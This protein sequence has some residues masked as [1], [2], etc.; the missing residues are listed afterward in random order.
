MARWRWHSYEISAFSSRIL[1]LSAAGCGTLRASPSMRLQRPD[2][3]M[4]CRLLHKPDCFWAVPYATEPH[5]LR[6]SDPCRGQDRQ[7]PIDDGSI[8]NLL[9]RRPISA[10]LFGGGLYQSPPSRG[11]PRMDVYSSGVWGEAGHISHQYGRQNLHYQTTCRPIEPGF[12]RE[13]GSGRPACSVRSFLFHQ[14]I[15]A[16]EVLRHTCSGCK[17][18]LGVVYS[19]LR[20]VFLQPCQREPIAGFHYPATQ[21]WHRSG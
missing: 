7:I 11:I 13:P 19:V 6:C 12:P 3:D 18:Q 2:L 17:P 1:A 20:S 10:G 4:P 9:V 14:R 8:R 15:L 5:L 16:R 21:T